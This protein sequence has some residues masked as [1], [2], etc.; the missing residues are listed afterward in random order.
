MQ[1]DLAASPLGAAGNLKEDDNVSISN[2][3]KYR[4]GNYII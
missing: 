4:R 2:I 1:L 3:S